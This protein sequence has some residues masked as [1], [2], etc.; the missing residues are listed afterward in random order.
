MREWGVGEKNGEKGVEIFLSE[1]FWHKG[2]QVRTDR[3]ASLALS[4]H[5]DLALR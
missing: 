2:A 1:D 4:H 5:L 3:S